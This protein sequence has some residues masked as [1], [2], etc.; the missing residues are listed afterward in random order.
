M[1]KIDNVKLNIVLIKI[2]FCLLL[3]MAGMT[4]QYMVMTNNGGKMPFYAEYDYEDNKYIS[5]NDKQ[6]VKYPYLS[7]IIKLPPGLWSLGDITMFSA[8]LLMIYVSF[9]ALFSK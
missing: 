6:E 9:V 5:F 8:T 3:L 7:D 4:M 2:I 1:E